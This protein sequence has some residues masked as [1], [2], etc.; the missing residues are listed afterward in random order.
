VAMRSVLTIL[1]GYAA[2]ATALGANVYEGPTECIDT[3]RIKVADR[4]GIHYV[5][6]IDSSSATG[7]PGAEFD[8]SRKRDL[9]LDVVVGVGDM[10]EGWDVGLMGLCKGAKAV[11]VIPPEMAYGDSGV[12]EAIPGGATLRFDIEVVS[13]DGPPPVLDIFTELDVDENG[14]LSPEEIDVHFKKEG[15]NAEMPPDLMANDD[16]NGDG[17][18]SREEFGGP[19]MPWEMCLEMLHTSSKDSQPTSLG[20]AVQWICRRPRDGNGDENGSDEL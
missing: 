4:V 15:P 3:D 8:S 12:G 5:G 2:A 18:I 1:L 9:V 6:T 20:L 19:K 7:E 13:V 11:V 10:I 17:V 14:F 16:A